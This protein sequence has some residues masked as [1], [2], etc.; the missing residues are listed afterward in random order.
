[1]KPYYTNH[2]VSL[3][4]ADCRDLLLDLPSQSVD[5]LVT[6]P[7]YG[8]AWESKVKGA[9]SIRADGTRQGMRVLREALTSASRAL[10][11][12]AHAYV[13]CHWQSWPDFYDACSSHLR[14]R[15]ARIWRKAQG[16]TGDL[17]Q[18]YAPDYEVVLFAAQSNRRALAG[19]REGAVIAGY[20]PVPPRQRT[21][22]TEKPVALLAHLLAKSCP[23]G[24]LVLD[25]FAGTGSTLVAAQQLG[26]RAVGVEL[27]ESHCEAAA[28]RLDAAL[29][30]GLP[31]A[32]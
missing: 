11:P 30:E 2:A 18:S 8:M 12:D 5:A 13:F 15:S 7:P 22:P 10:S 23:T 20:P 4:N 21:H 14:V 32:S 16:G 6:D 25:P 29:R 26:L 27:N 17:R 3:Y 24:G 31:R 28:R 19:K 9:K 1:M